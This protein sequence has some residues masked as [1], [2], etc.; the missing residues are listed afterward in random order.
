MRKL[1]LSG[2]GG[3]G[4]LL[5]GQLLAYAA[6]REGK[7]STW[8]PTYGA[9]VRGGAAYCSV[10]ISDK[11]VGSPVIH[12]ADILVACS[13]PSLDKFHGLVADGGLVIYH[14][15]IV[16]KIDERAGVKYFGADFSALAGSIHFPKAANIVA[17]GFL[18][19][20]LGIGRA[21]AS[22]ALVFKFG[23]KPEQ[24]IKTNEMA[25]DLGITEARRTH[26]GA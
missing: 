3:Q 12:R 9:E 8:F 2:Y 18:S 22:E 16:K 14:S 10:V 19:E 23:G 20:L 11:A 24:I 25:V 13:Q 4:M 15:A 5:C 1:I 17:L 21:S 7:H 6:M 26:F